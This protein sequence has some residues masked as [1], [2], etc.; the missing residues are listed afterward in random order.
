MTS[1]LHPALP[2][3]SGGCYHDMNVDAMSMRVNYTGGN[4]GNSHMAWMRHMHGYWV[5][6]RVPKSAPSWHTTSVYV[7]F[8]CVYM[9]HSCFLHLIH[10]WMYGSEAVLAGCSRRR[11]SGRAEVTCCLMVTRDA[12]C[13]SSSLSAA[14]SHQWFSILGGFRGYK[15]EQRRR[16]MVH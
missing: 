9:H 13:H 12:L 5:L 15:L 6:I 14:A 1:S 7:I 2:Y 4:Y 10:F 3:L 11:R 16:C 8:Y